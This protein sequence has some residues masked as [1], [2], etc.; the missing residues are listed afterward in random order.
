MPS[1][2]YYKLYLVV[3]I[4]LGLILSEYL[5]A[6]AVGPSYITSKAYLE[7]TVAEARRLQ[8]EA[9][10]RA[11]KRLAKLK[12]RLAAFQSTVKRYTLYRL[13]ALTPIYIGTLVVFILRPIAL[14]VPCCIPGLTFQYEGGCLTLA[15]TLAAAMFLAL[16][17]ITQEDLVLVL[18][19]KRRW[20]GKASLDSSKEGET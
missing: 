9:T 2:I 17:P 19:F 10:P 5:Y 16:L 14:A 12:T 8:S 13:A 3:L 20:T 1:L 7:G 6:A 4:T 11:R 18:M 15:A